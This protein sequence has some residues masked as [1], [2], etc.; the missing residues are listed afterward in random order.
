MIQTRKKYGLYRI[1]QTAAQTGSSIPGRRSSLPWAKLI[2]PKSSREG[3]PN[4]S[5]IVRMS[6][7]PA[8]SVSVALP[9]QEM[10]KFACSYMSR[11]ILT[12]A[13]FSGMFICTVLG[14]PSGFPRCR[15]RRCRR[16][17]GLAISPPCCIVSGHRRARA[18]VAGGEWYSRKESSHRHRYLLMKIDRNPL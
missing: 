14:F 16:H 4:L 17:P 7:K 2:D 6:E 3:A 15:T 10:T 18:Q 13:V 5:Y 11:I 9:S 12:W 1:L 8:S